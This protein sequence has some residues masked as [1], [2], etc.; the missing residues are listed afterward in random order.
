MAN[1]TIKQYFDELSNDYILAFEGKGNKFTE[2]IA[3]RLF[4]SDTFQRRTEC[5]VNII[6]KI[7]VL[8][9]TVLDIGCGPGHIDVLISQ[10][11][12]RRVV[13]ID[14]SQKMIEHATGLS[15]KYNVKEKCNFIVGDVFNVDFP[16]SDITLII[17]VLEYQKN[18]EPLLKK[19]A[20]ST[21][22]WIILSHPKRIWWMIVLRKIFLQY[23]KGLPVY[24]HTNKQLSIMLK[25][26]GFTE[27]EAYD[28]GRF[29]VVAFKRGYNEE[30]SN[31]DS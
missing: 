22:E 9:K 4:R 18:P 7:G 15:L 19:V 23:I 24:F 10:M 3:N 1:R 5:V 30:K 21:N 11:G 6:K 20:N 16:R 26:L 29:T 25:Q 28:L 2:K 17:A 14:I 8:D 12:V 27:K 13:G 31:N